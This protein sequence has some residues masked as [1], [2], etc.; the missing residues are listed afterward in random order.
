[1]ALKA[2]EVGAYIAGLSELIDAARKSL[3]ELNEDNRPAAVFRRTNLH[4]T[5]ITVQRELGLA[6]QSLQNARGIDAAT[7]ILARI[8]AQALEARLTPRLKTESRT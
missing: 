5:I 4:A 8:K 6:R 2:E 7:E 1:M 3:A